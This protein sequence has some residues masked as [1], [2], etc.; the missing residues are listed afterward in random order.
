MILVA[1]STVKSDEGH[2]DQAKRFVAAQ[3]Q[4]P[5]VVAQAAS[6]LAQ[7]KSLLAQ[8]QST[9][10]I[11]L[12]NLRA[13]IGWF[14]PTR[15]PTVDPNWPASSDVEPPQLD[16]LVTTARAHRPDIIQLDKLILAADASLT[17]AHDERRP[18]L[19]ASAQTLWSPA[20]TNWEP[21]PT[22]SAGIS[23]TWLAWDGGKSAA[24]VRVANANILSAQANRDQLLLTLT[25]TLES[26]RSQIV[27]NYNNVTAS[28]EAVT[29]ARF[30]LKL[31]DAR[32]AHGLGSQI[33]LAD[34]QTAVT[35]AEGTLVTAEWQLADAWSQLRRA[36]GQM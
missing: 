20:T 34:A 24:D 16:A 26:A 36:T 23:L 8:A 15:S 21:E 22:W 5:I 30:A 25:S 18:Y 19:S 2:L 7:A 17:A 4:D 6:A 29:S 12:G 1:Q 9:E 28:T 35:T 11:A 33:E 27:A 32:Y 10:A 13:A 3:A 31:A 14:D